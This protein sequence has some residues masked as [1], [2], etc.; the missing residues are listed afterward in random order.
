VVAGVEEVE[1]EEVVVEEGVV[2]AVVEDVNF[3]L[4]MYCIVLV[5]HFLYIVYCLSL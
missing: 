4:G 2:E 3:F 1:E 5:K